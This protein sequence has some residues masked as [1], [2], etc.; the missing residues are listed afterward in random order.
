MPKTLNN[1][2][3]TP[4]SSSC[5]WPTSYLN[6]WPTSFIGM[7][8]MQSKIIMAN[9]YWAFALCQALFWALYMHSLIKFSLQS[10]LKTRHWG[11]MMLSPLPRVRL[12]PNTAW[13]PGLGWSC[14]WVMVWWHISPCFLQNVKREQMPDRVQPRCC[15]SE[16]L[17]LSNTSPLS[18]SLKV[19]QVERERRATE[20]VA[21]L[22]STE[23]VYFMTQT[24]Y[25]CKGLLHQ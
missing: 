20:A 16:A 7:S 8:H 17:S 12:L 2:N 3:F 9:T 23:N 13:Q 21:W 11:T 14:R 10:V 19:S 6:N 5:K 15:C 4:E 18:F 24:P 25:L 1:N 22:V